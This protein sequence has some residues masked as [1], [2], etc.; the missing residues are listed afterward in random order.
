ML[1]SGCWAVNTM[2]A[3]ISYNVFISLA[4]SEGGIVDCF[5]VCV[6]EAFLISLIDSLVVCAKILFV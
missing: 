4:T 6:E 3:V 1:Q 5:A 2:L